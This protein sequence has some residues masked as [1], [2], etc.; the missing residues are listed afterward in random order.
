MSICE[1]VEGKMPRVLRFDGEAIRARRD[2]VRAVDH[3]LDVG[4]FLSRVEYA[5]S[6]VAVNLG[7]EP[8]LPGEM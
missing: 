7:A 2:A 6:F 1:V 8:L 3:H 4:A 5:E